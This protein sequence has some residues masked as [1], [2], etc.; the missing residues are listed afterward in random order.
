MGDT[1]ALRIGNSLKLI[2][3]IKKDIVIHSNCTDKMI[4]SV[5]AKSKLFGFKLSTLMDFNKSE[6]NIFFQQAAFRMFGHDNRFRYGCVVSDDKQIEVYLK[7]L[8]AFNYTFA[9]CEVVGVKNGELLYKEI[10]DKII[11]SYKVRAGE[12]FETIERCDRIDTFNEI[13]GSCGEETVI[14]EIYGGEHKI[15]GVLSG[16]EHVNKARITLDSSIINEGGAIVLNCGTV[17]HLEILMWGWA[18]NK[19]RS[20]FRG[21]DRVGFLKL[22]T[23]A[24]NLLKPEDLDCVDR[25][26]VPANCDL[27]SSLMS[28]LRLLKK[29]FYT[30]LYEVVK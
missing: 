28:R 13:V 27:D 10:E 12:D 3:S 20:L 30:K 15:D 16:L 14:L 17:E 25:L 2:K 1:N 21:C 18:R 23:A 29:S 26:N 24:L 22:N 9:S 6:N 5:V 7:D 11:Y 4:E 8:I 19:P